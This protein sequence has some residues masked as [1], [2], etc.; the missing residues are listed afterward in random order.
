MLKNA[1]K[2]GT[3]LTR[4]EAK[5][6]VAG[7]CNCPPGLVCVGGQCVE[8]GDETLTC[9][10]C[11]CTD[12]DGKQVS[13]D[14]VWCWYDFEDFSLYMTLYCSGGPYLAACH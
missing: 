7:E 4:E 11:H 1:L 10:I 14:S 12:G 8:G 9:K 2:L 13:D 6:I 3:L 5:K